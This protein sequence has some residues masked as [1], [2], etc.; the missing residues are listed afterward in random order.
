VKR[1]LLA[2]V[3]ACV[4]GAGEDECDDVTGRMLVDACTE[5]GWS[6]IA[7]DVC[8]KDMECIIMS[9]LE[10]VDVDEVDV[11]LTCGGT[12]IGEDDIMPE[13]TE[14][15]S[16]RAV[17]GIPESIRDMLRR[18]WPETVL[19]RGVAVQRNS[20][21]VVNLPGRREP[22]EVALDQISDALSGVIESR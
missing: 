15:L 19:Y 4:D 21:V 6:V 3:L 14:R 1:E 2:G 9:L 13:A 10:M 12:G 8:A 22:A 7:Y 20:T 17:P 11:L 5:R 18:R 16:G